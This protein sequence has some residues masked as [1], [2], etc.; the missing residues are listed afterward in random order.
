MI[1]GSL[2]NWCGYVAV[3]P[4]HPLHG[5]SY[6]DRIQ[7]SMTYL[8][9]VKQREIDIDRDFGWLNVFIDAVDGGGLDY[10][11][12]S[13]TIALPAH[14]G[15]SFAAADEQQWWWFGFDCAWRRFGS[16][17]P[18]SDLSARPHGLPTINGLSRPRLRLWDHH[19]FG[20][21][22]RRTALHY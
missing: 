12:I 22:N 10:G 8:D 11:Y 3:P 15:L 2:G 17:V 6:H 18:G 5:K 14:H 16:H 9:E 13:L 20:L 19:A 1:R 21:G 7:V 4:E